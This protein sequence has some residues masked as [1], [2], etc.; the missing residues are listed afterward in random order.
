MQTWLYFS[1]VGFLLVALG[2]WFLKRNPRNK[3]NFLTITFGYL[4]LLVGAFQ[5]MPEPSPISFVSAHQTSAVGGVG[6]I[7]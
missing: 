4:L 7:R 6:Q 3:L 5:S 1:A 2:F